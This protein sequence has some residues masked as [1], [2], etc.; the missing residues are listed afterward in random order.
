MTK[1]SI[2]VRTQFIGK[3]PHGMNWRLKRQ[4]KSKEQAEELKQLE[5]LWQKK[6]VDP[7]ILQAIRNATAG[8]NTLVLLE[9]IEALE[10]EI[11][12]LK[13]RAWKTRKSLLQSL[14]IDPMQDSANPYPVRQVVQFVNPTLTP[15]EGVPHVVLE[16]G[17][18]ARTSEPEFP[19]EVCQESGAE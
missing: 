7:L 14:G 2:C 19:C 8:G 10:F 18:G 16:C 1:C 17:H 5:T 6:K 4:D 13:D 11:H 12:E 3:C 15:Q 9:H